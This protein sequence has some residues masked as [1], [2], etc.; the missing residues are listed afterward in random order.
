MA[1]KLPPVAQK[2]PFSQRS[3]KYRVVMFKEWK[4]FTVAGELVGE[5]E[6]GEG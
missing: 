4:K 6:N 3:G 2:K 1:F 5:E